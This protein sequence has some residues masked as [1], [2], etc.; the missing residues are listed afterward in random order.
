MNYSLIHR[1]SLLSEKKNPQT[2]RRLFRAF[3]LIE[4]LVV[5]AI[6]AILAGLLLPALAKAKQRAQRI[7][8]LNNLKQMSLGSQMYADDS[9]GHLIDDTHTYGVHVY[10]PNVRDTDDDD[11]NWL[12]PR[13]ISNLRSFICPSTRN[14]VNPN[15]TALYGDNFQKYFV[16][17][18]RTAVNKD[19]TTGHSYEVLGNIRVAT[20]GLPQIV[21]PKVTEGFLQSHTLKFNSKAIGLRPGPTAIWL[22]FDSDNG[23]FNTEPDAADC[24]GR[25]GGNVAYCDGH[26]AWVPRADWRRQWNITRD[27]NATS[28]TLPNM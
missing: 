9:Q 4:L 26:A 12:N 1:A 27:D 14:N 17:L 10:R 13:Y 18:S 6:I 11:L 23:G 7:S 25:D 2:P 22:I 24:H 28:A 19:A 16:E 5:I 8:C 15:L 20:T 21:R 3:T